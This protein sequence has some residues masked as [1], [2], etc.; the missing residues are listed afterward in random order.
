MPP[1]ACSCGCVRSAIALHAHAAASKLLLGARDT[2]AAAAVHRYGAHRDS[3]AVVGHRD[4]VVAA[5]TPPVTVAVTV[6]A[7]TP[8]T[9]TDSEL[10]FLS[11]LR[12]VP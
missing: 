2:P 3:D 4:A 11:G 12:P 8:T 9:G 10:T 1:S 7:I 5:T 6:T